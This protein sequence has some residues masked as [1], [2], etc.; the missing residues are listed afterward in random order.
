MRDIDNLQNRMAHEQVTLKATHEQIQAARA[1]IETLRKKISDAQRQIEATEAHIAKLEEHTTTI[2]K[3]IALLREY[4]E[5]V[6]SGGE[7]PIPVQSEP[8]IVEA[9]AD[10]D[11][12]MDDMDL[13]FVQPLPTTATTDTSTSTQAVDGP[14]SFETIE[15]EI[16]TDEVLPRTQTF[17]EEL[18]LVLAYHRKA[19]A[20]KDV[21][22]VFRRLDYAPKLS[23]T[24]KN[25]KTHVETDDHLF[26]YATGDKIAL[27]REGRA[28][29][30]RLLERLL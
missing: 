13:D 16:L 5:M 28:E 1:N 14:I 26:E 8:A 21:A 12:E 30:Q 7:P 24:S 17:G 15:E 20:A 25:V 4:M 18:L 10:V 23:P 22:R 11:A 3:R 2:E 6:E 27:T 19:L 9:A 29:A